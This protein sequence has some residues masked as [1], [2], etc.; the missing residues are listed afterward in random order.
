VAG[1][2]R[3]TKGAQRREFTVGGTTY[4]YNRP[5]REQVATYRRRVLAQYGGVALNTEPVRE[6]LLL[7]LHEVRGIREQDSGEVLTLTRKDLD[8]VELDPRE[9]EQ[10]AGHIAD[11][12]DNFLALIEQEKNESPDSLSGDMGSGEPTPS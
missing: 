6:F 5:T 2:R 11:E 1:F 7:V 4:V 12:V 9:S 10:V 8:G 3:K